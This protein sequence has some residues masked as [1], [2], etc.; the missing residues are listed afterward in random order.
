MSPTQLQQAVDIKQRNTKD[1]RLLFVMPANLRV[2][3]TSFKLS[4]YNC[5]DLA[6]WIQITLSHKELRMRQVHRQERYMY[7]AK[8]GT[9]SPIADEKR[10]AIWMTI[11]AAGLWLFMRVVDPRCTQH[12]ACKGPSV[13]S[14][15]LEAVLTQYYTAVELQLSQQV[16]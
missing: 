8:G 12:L 10:T 14:A 2:I 9:L 3:N 15:T 11:H 1:C 4:T 13:C 16:R 6:L 5:V 7:N